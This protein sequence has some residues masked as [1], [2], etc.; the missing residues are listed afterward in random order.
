[1]KQSSL[2]GLH[3]SGDRRGGGP[4]G[5]IVS[6][7]RVADGRRQRD[8]KIINGE[9][10]KYRAKN[11]SLQNT[12][13]DSKGTTFVILIDHRSAPFRKERLSPTSKAR[14]EASRNQFVEKD[15]MPDSVKSFSEINSIQDRPRA[16]PG[17]VKPIQNGL[18]KIQNLIECRPSRAETGLMGR[19]ELDSRKKSRRDRIMRSKSLDPQEVREIGRT[20]PGESRGFSDESD[21]R[22]NLQSKCSIN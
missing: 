10:E 8:R 4:N 19:M 6:V 17:F 13:T 16:R 12:S 7:K 1:M 11:E 15:G 9:S 22:G 2:C 3:R 21:H 18:R 20:E 5:Q 14:R